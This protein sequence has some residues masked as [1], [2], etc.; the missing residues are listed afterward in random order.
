MIVENI[1]LDINIKKRYNIFTVRQGRKAREQK[2][3]K[4]I[5]KKCLTKSRNSDII[6]KLSVRNGISILKIEQCEEKVTT[7]EIPF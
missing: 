1:L 6:L 3:S 2:N 4:E 7:L 5:L